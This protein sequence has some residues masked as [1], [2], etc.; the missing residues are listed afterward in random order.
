MLMSLI[1]TLFSLIFC[2]LYCC[3][4]YP[5]SYFLFILQGGDL[6]SPEGMHPFFSILAF[7]KYH[8]LSLSLSLSLFFF[9]FIHFFHFVCVGDCGESIYGNNFKCD[10]TVSLNLFSISV[11]SNKPAIYII[12]SSCILSDVTPKRRLGCDERGLLC[13]NIA[14]QY[15][16][17]SHFVITLE[18]D[19][20]LDRFF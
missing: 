3:L 20:S 17:G 19:Q 7:Q 16:L 4:L 11:V 8:S 18:P 1:P 15:T 14:D 6:S 9:H 5:N 12:L 2:A 13:M 10:N